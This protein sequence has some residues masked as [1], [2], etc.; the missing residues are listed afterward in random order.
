MG[1]QSIAPIAADMSVP[2]LQAMSAVTKS[3]QQFLISTDLN[4]NLIMA[5]RSDANG[6]LVLTDTIGA[7]DGLGLANPTQIA[8]VEIGDR[9]FVIV[10]GSG[11]N[12]LSV[13]EL[14][15]NGGLTA[16][17][18]GLDTLETRFNGVTALSAINTENRDLVVATGT[19]DGFSV[20]TILPNGRLFHEM[21]VTDNLDTALSNSTAVTAYHTD[22]TLSLFVSSETE[23]GISQFSADTSN[24]ESPQIGDE[25]PNSLAGSAKDDLIIGGAGNDTLNGNDGADILSDGTGNDTLSGGAGPDSFILSFDQKTDV[26]PISIHCRTYWICRTTPFFMDFPSFRSRQPR[27]EHRSVILVMIPTSILPMDR[28]LPPPISLVRVC[29]IWIVSPSIISPNPR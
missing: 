25:T 4:T 24:L 16:T 22:D 27:Q 10:G 26:T 8:T 11:S 6:H 12:S 1:L 13:V 20:F 18:H 15:K 5:Y 23:N 2:N 28:P 14:S 21:S 19:D 9:S 29:S 17:D 7:D 3:N